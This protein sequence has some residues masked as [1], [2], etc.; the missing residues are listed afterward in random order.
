MY[1]IKAQK[2]SFLTARYSISIEITANIIPKKFP[3]ITNE[4]TAIIIE[5]TIT[6][7]SIFTINLPLSV[8]EWI[9][10]PLGMHKLNIDD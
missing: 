2:S 7:L 1:I 9:V 5:S 3:V 8:G 6:I 10:G 4:I